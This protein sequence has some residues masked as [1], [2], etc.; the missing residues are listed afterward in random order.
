MKKMKVFR[1]NS[2]H[3]QERVNWLNKPEI[4]SF[5]NMQ[6]PIDIEQTQKWY[7]KI[8]KDS[9]RID[10]VFSQDNDVVAM[11]G[12]TSLDLQNQ[13]VEFYIFVNPE[14]QGR[15]F[16]KKATVFSL[17][18][19]FTNYNINKI[20]LYTN[21]FNTKANDLYIKLGFELE[22]K[23]RQ[24]KFKDGKNIDRCIY[25]L[26]RNDWEKMPYSTTNIQLE[27]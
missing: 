11:T 10:F 4:Y 18:W 14:F 26:L 9:S 7:E 13:L 2:R 6:Y 27:I 12:L 24:H 21:D 20:Y 8:T 25:G 5:L 23:L 3:L 1:I 17:N 19:A 15:G 16:G 22:G